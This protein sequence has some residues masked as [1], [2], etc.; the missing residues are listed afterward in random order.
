MLESDHERRKRPRFELAVSHVGCHDK[1]HA[2]YCQLLQ[3]RRG[4]SVVPNELHGYPA[5]TEANIG[6]GDDG[7]GVRSPSLGARLVAFSAL[8]LQCMSECLRK[9]RATRS[10]AA[11]LFCRS[12]KKAAPLRVRPFSLP[13]GS[14]LLERILKPDRQQP[15]RVSVLNIEPLIFGTKNKVV[16]GLESTAKSECQVRTAVRAFYYSVKL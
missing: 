9:L 4:F 14:V 15:C 2:R 11:S 5:F 10:M 16:A 1:W 6:R 13:G 7:F 8:N 3:C 12:I